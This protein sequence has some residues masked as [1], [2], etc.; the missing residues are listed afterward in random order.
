MRSALGGEEKSISVPAIKVAKSV[1]FL[2]V[3]CDANVANRRYD[4]E[5]SEILIFSAY[6]PFRRI[7]NIPDRSNEFFSKKRKAFF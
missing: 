2:S 6:R 3:L 7:Q 5:I 4:V 1:L